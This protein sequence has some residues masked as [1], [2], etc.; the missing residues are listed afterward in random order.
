MT[1]SVLI[2]DD[3][4]TVRMDLEEAFRE[5][6]FAVTLCGTKKEAEA[7]LAA[8]GFALA[9]LDILLPDG[10]GID[11]LKAIKSTPASS[12]MAVLL[13]STE[14]EVRDRVRGL[15][16]G[17]DGYVGKPYDSANVVAR[18]L[19]LTRRSLPA[20]PEGTKPLVLVIDD[21]ATSR[22][23]MKAGLEE[24]GYAV[25]T[26]PRGEDGLR[27][28]AATRPDALIIDGNMPGLDGPGVIRQLRM[29]AVFRRTPCLLVTG[30]LDRH[31]EARAL[32]AGAD[33]F[34]QKDENIGVVLARLGAILRKT[35]SPAAAPETA[36]L[37]A[38]KRI[39]AVDDSM[40]YLEELSSQLREEGYEVI[41]A[42]SGQEALDL[43]TVQE[44]DCILMDCVMPFLSGKET[45]AR[46][47][48]NSAWRDIP[49]VLITAHEEGEAMIEGINAG[50]DDYIK[51]SGDFEVLKARL[52][53][54]IRRKQFEDENRQIREKLLSRELEAAE[55]RASR[56]LAET[57]ASLLAD[58]ERKNA[59]L[60]KEIAE[61]K[62]GE[63]SLRESEERFRVIADSSPVM[64]WMTDRDGRCVYV[65]KPWLDFTG[66][67]M[68][69]ELG[70]GWADRLHPDDAARA[71]ESF[72]AARSEGTSFKFEAR[73]RR[74]DGD[75][76]WVLDHGV[77]RRTPDGTVVGYIGTCLDFSERREIEQM[78]N[79]FISV[80]SHELRTP[81]TAIRGSLGL[82]AAGKTGPLAEK[83]KTMVDI[84]VTS[85]DRLVRLI[86]DILDIEKIESGKMTFQLK[87]LDLAVLVEQAVEST[88][89]Y[90][91]RL[92]VTFTLD[93]RTR[94][95][96]VRGDVDRLTQVVLNL[97][98]NAAKFSPPKSAVEVSVARVNGKIRVAVKDRGPGIPEE[99][100]GRIFQK[101][102][103]ADSSDTRQKGGTGLG[104][105]ISKAIVEKH[106]GT[107]YF[108]TETGAGTTFFFDLPAE[109]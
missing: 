84:A 65:S 29:D 96:R 92:G 3:S 42:R 82:I 2:V 26:A 58:L 85:T 79:E 51:K 86:N 90:G 108:E 57:R 23:Q 103:Q 100:Q 77:P 19:D 87:P 107:I 95:L 4:L 10:D 68:E 71:F 47:K 55:A 70:D 11:L 64:I 80:V 88:R 60:E 16:T 93:T 32:D 76:R 52:R 81:L 39:L 43:L 1:P 78:K 63:A 104:L 106:G 54:Q 72:R 56:E 7:A 75:Y 50:A 109:A 89:A 20:R 28:A 46:I 53:A 61:R 36:S 102:S 49:L 44:V 94:D 27:V 67:T 38:P 12:G 48:K 9:V 45:C 15:T 69:D 35:R 13:L 21:S 83:T 30:T 34:I 25:L 59:D 73:M 40:T 31:E 37:S 5:A 91:D 99:F 24:A 66:R 17:A 74:W 101:F 41:Q 6:G 98:S 33:A 97:L 22:E 18:A 62:R 8:G 14:A 105:N